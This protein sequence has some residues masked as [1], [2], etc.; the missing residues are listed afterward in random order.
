MRSIDVDALMAAL[1]DAAKARGNDFAT[2]SNEELA[3]WRPLLEFVRQDWLAKAK[4]KGV[5][6]QALLSDLEA[7]IKALSS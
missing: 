5:D 4:E 6:G 7:T 3:K 2:L 1:R